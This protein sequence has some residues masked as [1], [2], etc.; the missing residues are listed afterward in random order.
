MSAER[1][2]PVQSLGVVWELT[3]RRA[4][5]FHI[6]YDGFFATTKALD[7]LE[8]FYKTKVWT[9]GV[10]RDLFGRTHGLALAA[11]WKRLLRVRCLS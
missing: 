3:D 7:I 10:A 1:L 5:R 9:C 2:Q 8:I 6:G 11:S 4:R